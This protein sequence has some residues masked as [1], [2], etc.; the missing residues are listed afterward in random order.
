VLELRYEVLVTDPQGALTN[1]CN[2]HGVKFSPDM[3]QF[4]DAN[5]LQHLEP[6]V[7]LD[8]KCQ[9]LEP[10]DIAAIG[11]YKRLLSKAETDEFEYI[12]RSELMVI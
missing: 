12:A 8:W 3:L 9:N 5:W 7:T 11:R 4:N 2:W 10:V 1:I 6:A